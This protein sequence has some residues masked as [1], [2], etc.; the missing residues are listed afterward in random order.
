MRQ[1]RR[2]A[3]LNE[4]E[5]DNADDIVVEDKPAAEAQEENRRP[6]I[7][8]RFILAGKNIKKESGARKVGYRGVYGLICSVLDTARLGV[9]RICFGP[10]KI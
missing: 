1:D 5:P 10:G 4:G 2:Q 9:S 8:N 3:G 7:G 6:I